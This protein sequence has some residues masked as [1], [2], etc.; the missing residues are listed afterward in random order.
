MKKFQFIFIF[1]FYS[2]VYGQVNL[3]SGLVGYYNFSYNGFDSSGFSNHAKIVGDSYVEDRFGHPCCAL[4]LY[5]NG[6]YVEFPKVITLENSEWSYSIWFKLEILPNAKDDAFL[7]SYKNITDGDD[8]HLYVDNDDNVIKIFGYNTGSKTSTGVQV[9][10]NEWYHVVVTSENGN[11]VKMYVNG[12]MQINK[13]IDFINTGPSI[14]ISSNY[15]W[16]SVKGRVWG[17]VDAVRFYNRAINL[18]EA[19]ALYQFMESDTLCTPPPV[20][21]SSEITIPNIFTPNGDGENDV[22]KVISKNIKTFDCKI[23]NRWGTQVAEL[24]N[25]SES[26]DGKNA[27]AG[28]YYYIILAEGVD[29]KKYEEKGFVEVVK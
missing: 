1:C 8:V 2:S 6:E 19:L 4:K 12:Q 3:Q 9:I 13:Y 7:L 11:I 21:P 15:S 22:F 25:A 28:V 24:K 14:L 20:P 5:G 17:A 23:Y 27:T 26:W 29:G 16:S 18:Q 10:P